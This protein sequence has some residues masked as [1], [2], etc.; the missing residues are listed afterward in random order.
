MVR[1]GV[2]CKGE[3]IYV[4]RASH[5]GDLLPA[6]VIPDKRTAYV[7]YGG[8]E[9]RKQEIEVLCFIT[10]EWEYGSNGSV[11][12]S[13]LQIGQTAHG[14]PLYMGRARYRGSQTPGKVHPSHHCCYLPF[15][16]EEV[17]VKE[18]E[19]LCMR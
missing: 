18:Y 17:S 13:A 19:V 1:A 11:P 7:C 10:F 8:K 9:I 14:E 15:G 4:G 3:V 12:D 16:G 5:N 2:D 6:K